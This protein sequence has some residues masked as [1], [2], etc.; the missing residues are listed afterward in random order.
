MRGIRI[1]LGEI[2]TVL[3]QHKSVLF[4]VV[5]ASEYLCG[6]LLVAYVVQQQQSKVNSDELRHFLKQKLPGYM[7]PATFVMLDTLPLTPNGKIDRLALKALDFPK[8]NQSISFLPLTPIEQK[9]A[10][11]WADV[12]KLQVG[13][14][15]NFFSLGGHSLL[16][17]QVISRIHQAFNTKFTLRSLFETPTIA[18]FAQRLETSLGAN[19]AGDYEEG[20]I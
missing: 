12:L 18:E 4:A 7:V 13:I 11:I 2:E 10:S 20:E 1:E 19:I 6:Q 15:D 9:L 8:P 17:I 14:N 5:I 3:A 16:A